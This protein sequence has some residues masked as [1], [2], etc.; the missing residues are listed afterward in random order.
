MKVASILKAKGTHV[1]TIAP[2]A[3]VRTAVEQMRRHRIG[4]LVVS[5]TGDRIVGLIAE[6]E[7]VHGLAEHGEQLLHR[8][9]LDVMSAAVVTATS[10]DS[11][12]KVMAQMTRYRARHV[13]IVDAGRLVGLVSIGDVVKHRLDEL[14]LEANILRDAFLARS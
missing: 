14:E 8:Q 6:R 2:T 5:E 11:L 4:S 1:A 7:V 12:T 13:P 10:E 9:V 3:T